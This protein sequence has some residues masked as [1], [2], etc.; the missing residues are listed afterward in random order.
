MVISTRKNFRE[1]NIILHVEAYA[2]NGVISK[3]STRSKKCSTKLK[4]I[5]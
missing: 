2:N 1:N 5:G 4:T 3:F